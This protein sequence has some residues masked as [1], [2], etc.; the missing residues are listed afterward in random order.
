MWRRKDWVQLLRYATVVWYKTYANLKGENEKTYL[1]C[2]WWAL[3]PMINTAVFYVVFVYILKNR[4]EGFVIF[5]YIGMVVYGWFANGINAGA[6]SIVT[7]AGLMQQIKLPKLLFPI[8]SVSNLSW[9]FVFSLAVLFPLIWILHAPIT[10]AYL[11]LPF[12][13][14]LQYFVII[15][16]GLPFAALIPYFQDGRTVIAT[17]LSVFIW[18]SGVFY[19]RAQVPENLQDIFYMNPA[20]ALIE[21]YRNIL[22]DGQWPHWM[23]LVNVLVIGLVFFMIG[24]ILLRKVDKHLLKLPL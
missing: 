1:G 18:L 9:K 11:A 7:H 22:L 23:E 2:L 19:R 17:F 5:L 24:M 20:A 15:A 4:T 14:M 12:L 3:E 21:A 13:L 10:W 16:I 6:N 8:I